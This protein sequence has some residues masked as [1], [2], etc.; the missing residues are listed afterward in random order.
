MTSPAPTPRVHVGGPISAD[1]RRHATAAIVLLHGLFG[2]A[3]DT[4]D[5]WPALAPLQLPLLAVDLPFHGRSAGVGAASIPS[6]AASV[7][8]AVL[9]AA[10]SLTS[11]ILVGYSLGG[12]VAL[13]VASAAAP[14]LRVDG[15]L[16]VSAHPGGL[17][18]AEAASRLRRDEAT[19][20]AVASADAATFEAWLREDWFA[21]P[22]WGSLRKHPAFAPLLDRRVR[23][24]RPARV[25]DAIRAFS[26]AAAANPSAWPWIASG[27]GGVPLV[28]IYG[29]ADARYAGVGSRLS[30]LRQ[31]G[32]AVVRVPRVG[33]N[34]LAEAP[35]AVAIAASRLAWRCG[36]PDSGGVV[37]VG[38]WVRRFSVPLTVPMVVGGVRVG[39][40]DGALLYLVGVRVPDGTG[41]G[42]QD[43]PPRQVVGVAEVSPLPGL[44]AASVDDAVAQ[45]AAVFAAPPAAA[46]FPALLASD[47]AAG[48]PAARPLFAHLPAGLAAGLSPAVALA[49]EC[50]AVQV[51]AADRLP[52]CDAVAA[53]AGAYGPS[54][55]AVA[56]NAVIPRAAAGAGPPVVAG[57][58]RGAAVVKVKV[59]AAAPAQDA[60]TVAALLA[61]LPPSVTLRLDANRS[62]TSAATRAFVSALAAAA[63]GPPSLG[64]IAYV[65]EPLTAA[66]VAA[67]GLPALAAAVSGPPASIP[68]AL[69]ESLVGEGLGPPD[70]AGVT[71][72]AAVVLK[73]AVLGGLAAAVRVA[74][75]WAPAVA[76]AST[77][78]DG[79]VGVAWATLLASAL[80]AAAAGGWGGGGSGLCGGPAHG[81]GTFASLAADVAVPPLTES[82]WRPAD[83]ALDVGICAELL[84]DVAATA[85]SGGDGAG[86]RAGRTAR[87][88]LSTAVVGDPQQLFPASPPV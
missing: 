46:L 61:T 21:A 73:P 74:S 62:W 44:H 85:P 66:E 83:S 26:P 17:D 65:E 2:S 49:V 87:F 86:V 24:C 40:R 23:G 53:L 16:L 7:V 50:A 70:D 64:R 28:Y 30:A 29:A 34:V 41:R 3:A 38:A 8:D 59:G 4:A 84:A 9:A 18:A 57:F 71:P 20:N 55:D 67:G 58:P 48:P 80:D 81:L 5:M 54:A 10:P 69:D 32:V 51:A 47:A 1:G 88:E 43:A 82:A 11:A 52:L 14:R 77:V 15:V 78:F 33:H 37:L 63:G 22:M 31:P 75:A 35:H 72:P 56:V 39:R 13:A 36:R 25:A 42:S 76:V 19:A 79:A 6:A 12:R 68:Y 27:R 45:L 60:A